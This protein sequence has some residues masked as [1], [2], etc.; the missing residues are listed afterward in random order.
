MTI[1][2]LFEADS[3]A[4]DRYRNPARFI[5]RLAKKRLFFPLAV[6]VVLMPLSAALHGQDQAQAGGE[7][8]QGIDESAVQ[9]ALTRAAQDE[10]EQ[11]SVECIADDEGVNVMVSGQLFTR[12]HSG[13]YDKPILFPVYGPGQ[14]PMTRNLPMIESEGEEPD[15]P[16][17]KSIWV[18]HEIN[19]VDFW[20]E[21]TGRVEVQQVVIETPDSF[22][23]ASNWIRK[24]DGAVLLTDRTVFGFGADDQ[25]R[26]MDVTITFI[27]S[28]G[29]VV[30]KDTKE[31]LFAIRVHPKLRAREAPQHGVTDVTGQI[32]NA[33]GIT[34]P[35]CWGKP[36]AWVD[37]SGEV[38][39]QSVGIAVFDHPGNLRHPTT[40]H[41]RDYG[42]FAANPFGLHH[43]TGAEAGTGEYKLAEGEELTL[44]YRAV[45]HSG[46]C[47]EAD[48][49]GR[50]ARWAENDNGGSAGSDSDPTTA[51]QPALDQND[52]QS[53]GATG[54]GG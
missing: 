37:Y 9:G 16:H 19:H 34:G 32:T 17:H 49:P 12:Y 39:R 22:S 54:S 21:R 11:N 4:S 30:F 41:A 51:I 23:A 47:E 6:F 45:F 29:E 24:E 42:L 36:A 28:H 26:W 52:G 38:N 50:Y 25:S 27:A 13:G 8:A 40:W 44:R 18:G 35:E 53:G 46:N 2:C 43:F 15:H 14:V 5:T 7:P 1:K 48:V 20:T 3:G 33:A 10:A 31:G